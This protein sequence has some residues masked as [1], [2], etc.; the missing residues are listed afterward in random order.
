MSDSSINSKRGND[1]GIDSQT[2]SIKRKNVSRKSHTRG[3]PNNSDTEDDEGLTAYKSKKNY[4]KDSTNKD[5]SKNKSNNNQNDE[6]KIKKT[7]KNISTTSSIL[8]SENDEN[9]NYIGIADTNHRSSKKS[10]SSNKDKININNKNN[11][12][13]SDNVGNNLRAS[14]E[15]I[16]VVVNAAKAVSTSS[17]FFKK[18][19]KDSQDN[20]NNITITKKKNDLSSNYSTPGSAEKDIS[21]IDKRIIALQSYLDKAR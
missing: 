7:K 19:D 1:S 2:S 3:K 10:P 8:N 12:I 17:E 9:N 5:K 18:N 11:E 16:N 14:I 15:K 20:N 6:K 4:N 21:E 13:K